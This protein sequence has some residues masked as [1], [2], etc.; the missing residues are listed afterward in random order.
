MVKAL[1]EKF[2][3][4]ADKYAALV[5]KQIVS[6]MNSENEVK[7]ENINEK[8]K[9]MNQLSAAIWR[10]GDCDKESVQTPDELFR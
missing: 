6:E 5:E 1:Q 8:I 10:L 4:V 7:F 9:M 2:I 3:N